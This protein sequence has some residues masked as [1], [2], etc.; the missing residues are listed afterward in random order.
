MYCV[1]ANIRRLFSESMSYSFSAMHSAM[2]PR[3]RPPLVVLARTQLSL[4][5]TLPSTGPHI[6]MATA[7]MN[8]HKATT[9]GDEAAI[10]AFLLLLLCFSS[11]VTV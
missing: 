5:S 1:V 11:S 6:D 8:N 2:D 3:H 4:C 10:Y 7:P 9:M